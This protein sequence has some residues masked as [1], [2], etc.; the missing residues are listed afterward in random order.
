[1]SDDGWIPDDEW[2]TIVR[3]VPIPSVDLVVLHDSGV[4]LG[5]RT[6]EPAKEEWFVPGGR[7]HKHETLRG[8]VH[9]VAKEELGIEVEIVERLGVYEHFYETAD[10]SDVDGKHYLA[11]GFVVKAASRPSDVDAQHSELRV[12]EELPV[13][14]HEYTRNYLVDAESITNGT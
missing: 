12:F 13:N 4:V 11:N 14:L 5:K 3:H 8:A 6:N 7:I 9:R 2:K 1:M 10:V